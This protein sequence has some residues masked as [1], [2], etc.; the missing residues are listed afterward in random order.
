MTIIDGDGRDDQG[1]GDVSARPRGPRWLRGRATSGVPLPGVAV[2][3]LLLVM[4][5]L[6]LITI[7]PSPLPSPNRQGHARAARPATITPPGAPP[8]QPPTDVYIA[9]TMASAATLSWQVPR[10]RPVGYRIYRALGRYTPSMIVGEVKNAKITHFTDN[11][12]LSPATTYVY[13]VTAFDRQRESAASTPVVAIVLPEPSPPPT[14]TDQPPGPLP[15]LALFPPPTFTPVAA[16]L[17]S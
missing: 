12:S 1:Q 13:T 17:A 10:P 7:P 11:E 6:A 8:L 5:A 4:V 3:L 2:A 14:P 9:G 15:T 16:R